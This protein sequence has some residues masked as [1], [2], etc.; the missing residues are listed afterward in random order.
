M[1]S[2]Q[3]IF[4]SGDSSFIEGSIITKN[5]KSVFSSLAGYEDD[6]FIVHATVYEV[7]SVE[8]IMVGSLLSNVCEMVKESSSTLAE[9]LSLYLGENFIKED[10]V[11]VENPTQ[12]DY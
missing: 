9:P 4:L 8:N 11:K 5:W 12:E 7:N 10:F 3:T 1:N 2:E 6:I